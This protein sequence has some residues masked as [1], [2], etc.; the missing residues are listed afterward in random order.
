MALYDM[1]APIFDRLFPV[2]PKT[3][4]F[5]DGLVA[6]GSTH[7]MSRS[8]LDIGSATGGLALD[9]ARRG[10]RATG[11]EPSG[12]MLARAEAA[13]RELGDAAPRFLRGAM[14]EAAESLR[15]RLFDLVLCLGNT[16]PHLTAPGEIG[17][18]L[19]AT[20]PI[21]RPRG[22][23]VLQLLNY[24][25]PDIGP[26]FVF[27]ELCVDSLVMRRRYEAVEG[28]GALRFVVELS[29][30]ASGLSSEETTILQPIGPGRLGEELE[31]AGYTS[32][33]R[34]GNWEGKPFSESDDAYLVLVAKPASP[35]ALGPD[36]LD[37]SAPAAVG[38]DG[39]KDS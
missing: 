7:V 34:C 11:M 4:D 24:G 25:K 6:P 19:E 1:L 2:N 23:L 36:A 32:F 28:S 31:A 39:E 22:N 27:P 14:P 5:L 20:R 21:V 37:G 38:V 9:M 17:R 29:D 8:L 12:A 26:G 13:G 33:N 15:G 35:T 16:L 30:E 10:W 3:L 18:F